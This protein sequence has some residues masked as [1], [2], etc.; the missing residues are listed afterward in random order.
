MAGALRVAPGYLRLR[1]AMTAAGQLVLI[2][3]VH[4]L[5]SSSLDDQT[6]TFLY[7]VAYLPLVGQCLA[8][9]VVMQL[10]RSQLTTSSQHWC[11]SLESICP[12]ADLETRLLGLPLADGQ[13]ALF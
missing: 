10:G 12:K 11:I 13:S 1:A 6:D 7:F 8:E 5:D 2:D 4:V 9:T 3:A